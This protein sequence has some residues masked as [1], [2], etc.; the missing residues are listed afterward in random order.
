M[1]DKSTKST[2]R[3][4]KVLNTILGSQEEPA[5]PTLSHVPID[6]IGPNE[7]QVRTIFNEAQLNELSNSIRENGV[8]LPL[9]VRMGT[10]PQ[11]YK[12]ELV[13]GERRL[14]AAKLAGLQTVPVLINDVKN[15]D[16]QLLAI[17]ENMQRADLGVVEK[18]NAIA[19]LTES[20]GGTDATA[21]AL[22]LCRRSV[23][24]YCRIYKSISYFSEITDIFETNA[25]SIDFKTAE[26]LAKLAEHLKLLRD[27]GDDTYQTFLSE[28]TNKSIRNVID[29]FYL[30]RDRNKMTSTDTFVCN[31]RENAKHFVLNIKCPK[32]N[33]LSAEDVNIAI[34]ESVTQFLLKLESCKS[35]KEKVSQN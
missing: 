22:G 5:S 10:K 29:D 13:A 1:D 11:Q 25:A 27:S 15:S 6:Q 12:F 21:K 34:Q 32:K 4:D 31:L 7:C 26:T 24:R 30:F 3:V 19:T 16:M 20:L 9:I 14:R 8:L 23:E 33:E 28:L 18:T 35:E 2:K 17:L